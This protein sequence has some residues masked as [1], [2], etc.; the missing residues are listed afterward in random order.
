MSKRRACILTTTALLF[1]CA[2]MAG[3][4][5]TQAIE[6][7]IAAVADDP[8]TL[9]N[10][11]TILTSPEMQASVH[12]LAEALAR[13]MVEGMIG[14][15]S[16]IGERDVGQWMREVEP[17]LASMIRTVVASARDEMLTPERR[18]LMQESAAGVSAAVV[19]AM[20]SSLAA[21][22]E[23]D[24]AP[25]LARTMND[26]LGPALV[27]RL[28]DDELRA[29]TGTI[30]H[31]LAYQ[32]VLGTNAGVVELTSRQPVVAEGFWAGLARR[33]TAGTIALVVV[34]IMLVVLLI[35][36]ARQRR[37]LADDARRRELTLVS[38]VQAM[39]LRSATPEE[40]RELL[41]LIEPHGPPA[42][43]QERDAGRRWW[44][45]RGTPAQST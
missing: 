28:Q 44:S 39:T 43:E 13:G 8:Q 12:S 35:R 42:A 1:G 38:L 29:A 18:E 40:R 14:P 36:N 30:A 11:E 26:H 37:R 10:I 15:D 4:A 33:I 24:L 22:I 5:A 17:A 21:G 41:A 7:P 9:E 45:R 16:L 2:R 27:E 20:I 23:R 6:A 34:S 32:V 25:A 3:E 19:D 31:D